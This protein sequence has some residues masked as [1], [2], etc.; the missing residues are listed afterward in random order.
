[1]WT[2]IS[3]RNVFFLGQ[4]SCQGDSGGPLV[5]K[6]QESYFLMGIVSSGTEKCGQGRAGLYTRVS[7]YKNWILGNI[8]K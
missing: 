4:D 7:K 1:M 2:E 6:Y 5:G 8:R 3:L